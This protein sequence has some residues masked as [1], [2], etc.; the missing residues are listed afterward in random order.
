MT[1]RAEV[2]GRITYGSIQEQEQRTQDQEES[3]YQVEQFGI[4]LQTTCQVI[5]TLAEG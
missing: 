1:S 3:K 5:I 4:P 2:S